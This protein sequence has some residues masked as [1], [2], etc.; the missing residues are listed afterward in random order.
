MSPLAHEDHLFVE[1]Y[2]ARAKTITAKANAERRKSRRDGIMFGL[3]A[4]LSIFALLVAAHS[5]LS[6]AERE[7]QS[8]RRV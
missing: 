6:R 4:F 2:T 8:A 3:V 1:T 5:G 7:Y